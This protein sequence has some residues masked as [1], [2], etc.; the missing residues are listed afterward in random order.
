MNNSPTANEILRDVEF[1]ILQGALGQ[2]DLGQALQAARRFHLQARQELLSASSRRRDRELA[3]RQFQINDMLLSLLQ[4]MAARLRR[5]QV[6]LHRT[7]GLVPGAPVGSRSSEIDNEAATMDGR[8]PPWP[9]VSA[10]DAGAGEPKTTVEVNKLRVEANI[11]PVR[12][13]LVG[14]LLTRLRAALHTLPV[15]YT[16]RLA[17]QQMEVNRI[18]GQSLERLTGLV[19]EQQVQLEALWRQLED[20]QPASDLDLGSGEE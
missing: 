13:P 3:I 19:A 12:L 17:E 20:A 10:L 1:E 5:L 7:A 9:P 8:R 11:R 14:G 2:D 16:Q 6:E 18:L 4:E 15:F